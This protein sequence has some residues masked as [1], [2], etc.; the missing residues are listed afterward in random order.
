[1]AQTLPA[2]TRSSADAKAPLPDLITRYNLSS[3][4]APSPGLDADTPSDL[5]ASASSSSKAA[6]SQ[7]KNERAELLKKRREDMILAAR[8]KMETKDKSTS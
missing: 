6:W 7:N 3:K 4:I 5:S 8:R 1:M 2:T